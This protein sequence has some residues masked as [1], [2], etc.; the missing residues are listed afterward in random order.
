MN[1]NAVAIIKM[2]QWHGVS[3]TLWKQLDYTSKEHVVEE[4]VHTD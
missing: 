3:K 2:P 4:S 1:S